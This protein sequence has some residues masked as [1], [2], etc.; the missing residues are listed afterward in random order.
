[1]DHT[2]T[3]KLVT[4]RIKDLGYKVLE[5]KD[6]LFESAAS[7]WQFFI[8]T[9]G[10]NI[11]FRCYIKVEDN[12]VELLRF[13]N[14]FNAKKRFIKIYAQ[15]EENALVAESDWLIT[16][17]NDSETDFIRSVMEIWEMSLA[18]LK[19]MLWDQE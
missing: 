2:E 8:I 16:P 18:D 9:Y 3:S 7:G 5:L 14:D 15:I 1:M 19:R 12:D 10:T 11:Q 13:T 17:S 6:D 4:A